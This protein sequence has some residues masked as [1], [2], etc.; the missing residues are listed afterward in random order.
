MPAKP[1]LRNIA[2]PIRLRSGQAERTIH[3]CENFR[4]LTISARLRNEEEEE[5]VEEELMPDE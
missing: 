4:F 2:R 5:A 3:R 1:G